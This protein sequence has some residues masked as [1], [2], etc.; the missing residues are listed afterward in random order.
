MA[1]KMLVVKI[2]LIAGPYGDFNSSEQIQLNIDHAA[3]YAEALAKRR[4]GFICP[5]LNSAHFNVRTPEV[6]REFWLS[7]YL[8]LVTVSDAVL[9]IPGWQQSAGA[10]AEVTAATMWRKP[11]FE[12][13]NPDDMDE[14]V[15]WV[16]GCG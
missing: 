11:V 13:E 16:H 4:I 1:T 6:P 8:Q 15:S 3:K 10:N 5:H 12:P 14:L 9:A 2:V 7:M